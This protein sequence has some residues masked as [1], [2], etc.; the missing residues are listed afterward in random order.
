[1]YFSILVALR[2]DISRKFH[3]ELLKSFYEIMQTGL[4][5]IRIT[6][7][8]FED[9]TANVVYLECR[10]DRQRRPCLLPGE[11]KA[12]FLSFVLSIFILISRQL[13]FVVMMS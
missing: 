3:R 10:H 7:G 4:A 12:V 6:S 8:G 13:G 1:M 9:R 11:R 5:C 2:R